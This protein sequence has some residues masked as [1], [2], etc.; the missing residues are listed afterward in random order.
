MPPSPKLRRSK[1]GIAQSGP[2]PTG[3]D[4]DPRS[5]EVGS[6]LAHQGLIMY[7]VY[8]IESEK[9]GRYYIGQTDNLEAR[10]ERHNK[11]RNLS[12]KAYV[13]W[14]LKRWKELETRSE[15]MKTEARL[16]ANKN[17]DNLKKYVT[18]NKF[19]GIAQSG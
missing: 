19:R 18:E 15:A 13:P 6:G 1:R 10:I 9:D 12:T 11:K 4:E 5:D 8:V 7:Y 3:R 2:V 14:R 16:K 17:R